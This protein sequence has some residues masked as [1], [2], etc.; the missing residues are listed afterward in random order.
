MTDDTDREVQHVDDLLDDEVREKAV[1]GDGE[2]PIG[3]MTD[4]K[5]LPAYTQGFGV[6][7]SLAALAVTMNG[8]PVVPV[9]AI[10]GIVAIVGAYAIEKTDYISE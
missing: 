3:D 9:V 4:L 7:L 10:V 6:G 8:E 1:A 2:G 5:T